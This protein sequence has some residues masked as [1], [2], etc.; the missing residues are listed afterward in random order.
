[1]LESRSG[2][3]FEA[4]IRNGTLEDQAHGIWELQDLVA[5]LRHMN[6]LQQIPNLHDVHPAAD[7]PSD[8][9]VVL[10]EG[11][12]SVL[13]VYQEIQDAVNSFRTGPGG[14]DYYLRGDSNVVIVPEKG[15][16]SFPLIALHPDGCLSLGVTITIHPLEADRPD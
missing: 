7:D 15:G 10:G 16:P 1:M 14:Q 4:L 9:A 11:S 3:R 2:R 8:A 5:A 12:A 13:E 6:P